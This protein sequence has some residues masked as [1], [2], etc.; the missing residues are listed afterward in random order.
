MAAGW[1][2]G[3]R[4][5]G[6]GSMLTVTSNPLPPPCPPSAPSTANARPRPKNDSG[7]PASSAEMAATVP[8]P[9]PTTAATALPTNSCPVSPYAVESPPASSS[10]RYGGRTSPCSARSSMAGGR[11]TGR[12]PRRTARVVASLPNV[13]CMARRLPGPPPMTPGPAGR[14]T[15]KRAAS[16]ASRDAPRALALAL[17]LALSLPDPCCCLRTAST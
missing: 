17:P 2:V 6:A 1:N 11:V 16:P 5:S 9:C 3:G 13:C 12:F 4:S 14:S 15:D 7:R 10:I 8:P